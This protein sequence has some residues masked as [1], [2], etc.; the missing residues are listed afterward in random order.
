MKDA[1]PPQPLHAAPMRALLVLVA[2]LLLSACS[3]VSMYTDLDERQANEV[4]AALLAADINADKRTALSKTGWEVRVDRGDFARAMQVLQA[5]GL[6][7]QQYATMCDVFRKEG[8]ASSAIEEK[9]RYIC[10]RQQELARTLSS[11]PGVIEARVHI[12]LQERDQYGIPGDS[13]AAVV[14]FQQPG[15][16]LE[17]LR[18]RI[19]TV[20]KDG[21]EGLEDINQ[22]SV[23][24]V[25]MPGVAPG[26]APVR[27]AAAPAMKSS[28]M[29]FVAGAG[30]LALLALVWAAWGRWRQQRRQ[31][32]PGDGSGLWKG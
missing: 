25:S 1:H 32:A 23:E 30:V 4:L 28:A 6:P 11:Y 15:S 20:V 24:F 31:P 3:Q 27:Q 7:R 12:A 9:A 13:S 26:D 10:S 5:R 16:N 19:K 8:L 21:I 17:N 29:P 22:V 2:C 18:S 14:I